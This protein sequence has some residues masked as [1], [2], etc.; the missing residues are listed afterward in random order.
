MTHLPEE[1]AAKL[2]KKKKITSL[3][4]ECEDG[5]KKKSSLKDKKRS[6]ETLSCVRSPY[7]KGIPT[8]SKK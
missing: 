1:P 8:S 6:M 4:T 3:L 2:F 7:Q 5:K